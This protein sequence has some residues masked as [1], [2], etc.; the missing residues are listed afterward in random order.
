MKLF[1]KDMKGV[2]CKMQVRKELNRLEIPFSSIELGVV[3]LSEKLEI[4]QR[5]QLKEN[6]LRFGLE[7]QENKKSILI[8]KIK[9][10]IHEMLEYP[11][12]YPVLNHSVY[13]SEK[14]KYDYTYLA[15][16]FSEVNGISI[17]QY[18]I[19]SKIE[20]VKELLLF[21]EFNLSEISYNLHYSSVAHLSGQFKKVTGI[22]PS[23][24]KSINQKS[25]V[26]F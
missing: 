6:L 19:L 10:T 22:S 23:N 13:L 12:D 16:I 15:N 8:E 3:Q 21:S 24:F 26:S 1:I 4:D 17:K 25:L 18:I 5:N 20:R 9:N 14:L 2:K 11:D 7:L